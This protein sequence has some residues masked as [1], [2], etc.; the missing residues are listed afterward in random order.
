VYFRVRDLRS[1]YR[2]SFTGK[3]KATY[4]KASKQAFSPDMLLQNLQK[5]KKNVEGSSYPRR[6][7]G[8]WAGDGLEKHTVKR[9]ASNSLY[10]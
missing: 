9:E 10:A 2:E 5:K 6:K 7:G 1:T 8:R 4:R 3:E